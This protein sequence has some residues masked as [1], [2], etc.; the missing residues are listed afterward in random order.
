M[1]EEAIRNAEEKGVLPSGNRKIDYLIGNY[2]WLYRHIRDNEREKA[3]A[4]LA[5][6][7]IFINANKPHFILEELEKGHEPYL[8]PVV[9][10]LH[11][12]VAA[13]KAGD[14]ASAQKS[15]IGAAELLQE[16]FQ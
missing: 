5:E 10:A 12:A 6:L 9:Y 7:E 14:F 13:F 4:S 1:P 11:S 8:K 16:T 15:F 3:F 2:A